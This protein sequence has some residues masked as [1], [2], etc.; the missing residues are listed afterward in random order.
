L[1]QKLKEMK[2]KT[3]HLQKILWIIAHNL[4]YNRLK[5]TQGSQSYVILK[6]PMNEDTSS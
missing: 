3:K 2:L 4:R 1:A 5:D 6:M